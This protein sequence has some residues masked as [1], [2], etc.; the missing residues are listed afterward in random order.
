MFDMPCYAV[1]YSF[2][3]AH[4]FNYGEKKKKKR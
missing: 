1:F 3:D 4:E 2:E